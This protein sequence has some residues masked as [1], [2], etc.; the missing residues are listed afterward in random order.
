M[1][2]GDM[3]GWLWVMDKLYMRLKLIIEGAYE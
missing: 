1:C 3:C 2:G